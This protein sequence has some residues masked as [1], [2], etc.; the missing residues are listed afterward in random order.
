MLTRRILIVDDAPE[1]AHLVQDALA[2]MSIP[3]E[4]TIYLSGE[5]AWLEALR[6]RFDLVITDLRLPGISGTELVRRLRSRYPDIKIIA[7]SGLAEAGLTERTRAAGVDAFYRKPVEI[8]LLL[9]Q[10]DNFLSDLNKTDGSEK[11]LVNPVRPS[12]QDTKPVA[13]TQ[14][15]PHTITPIDLATM[16]ELE[17]CLLQLMQESGAEG[18]ALST[19]TGHVLVGFGSAEN[20]KPEVGL[21]ETFTLLQTTLKKREFSQ[22][23]S[24]STGLLALPGSKNDLIATSLGKFLFWFLFPPASQ[25]VETGKAA[26]A[27]NNSKNN[28]L[29]LLNL[30][31]PL[32][33]PRSPHP[34]KKASQLKKPIVQP[35]IEEYP[36][37][38]VSTGDLSD[39][40]IP[41]DE[42]DAFWESDGQGKKVGGISSDAISFDQASTLGILPKDE[43]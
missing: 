13:N 26:A 33:I 41:K 21:V 24:S 6:T 22:S 39:K 43:T 29:Y 11:P 15:K 2:T 42:V 10:I 5:E 4:T 34:P 17:R 36:L 40:P 37:K 8:P 18:V 25:S 30:V 9:T 1:F 16:H 20:Y 7:V 23:D 14:D 38:K 31:A 32:P 19:S 35:V 12:I 27:W 28:L 3:L